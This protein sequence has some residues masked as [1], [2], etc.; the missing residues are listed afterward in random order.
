MAEIKFGRPPVG[1]PINGVGLQ[2]FHRLHSPDWMRVTEDRVRMET[3][4]SALTTFYGSDFA[5]KQAPDGTKYFSGVVES[6]YMLVDGSFA[7]E[8]KGLSLSFRKLSHFFKVDDRE[9]CARFILRGD[10][11]ITLTKARD[12]L[13]GGMG[14]D[15][16][17]GK[18]QNDTLSGDAGDDSLFGGY[19][20]DVL[21]G[22][23]GHDLLSGGEGADHFQFRAARDGQADRIID[24]A[25]GEDKIVL[26]AGFFGLA[27]GTLQADAFHRGKVAQ[28]IEDRLIY[29]AETGR[30]F[31]D[32][33]GIGDQKAILLARLTNTPDL[34]ASD[35]LVEMFA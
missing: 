13:F 18:G 26:N 4:S 27:E 30:L 19:G 12:N 17:W 34:Q 7:M 35:F 3:F 21:T 15:V 25:L 1:L 32:A 6:I 14:D 10:D 2:F 20:E 16:L 11:Q 22:G 23:H 9:G 8:I 24:F 28:D 31:F 29:D 33:D 5:R